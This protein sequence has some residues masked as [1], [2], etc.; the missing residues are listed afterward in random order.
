MPI[1]ERR[2]WRQVRLGEDS[3]LEFKE[4]PVK[5]GRVP[6]S[7]RNAIA[8]ELAAFANSPGGRLVFG[9]TDRREVKPLSPAELDA[10]D[11]FVTELCNDS[12][13]PPLDVSVHR[14]AALNEPG[15]GV[16]VV[17]VAQGKTVHQSPGGCFRR[18]GSS[19][20][21]MEPAEIRRLSQLRG[22]SDAE[23]TDTQVVAETA[24]GS[25]D[26]ELWR[27]YA[28][29]RAGDPPET[30]LSKLKFAKE[31]ANGV[32]RATVGGVLL[33]SR[34]PREWLP[35]AFIQA[36]CYR[37]D[38]PDGNQQL[39]AMDIAGPLDQQ[40]RDAVRFVARNRRVAARKEPARRDVPQYSERAVFEA[41]VN[42]VVHRDYAVAG[43]KI[44]LFMFGDRLELHSPGGLGNSM[45]VEDMRISQFT[46][47]ELL[48]SRLGQCP[49]G[50]VAGAGG[51]QYFIER[52]GEG[53]GVIED[54][55]FALAGRKPVFEL[56]GEREL[57]LVLPAA[58]RPVPEG[59]AARVAV[60]HADTG[61]PIRDVHILLVYPNKTYLEARTDAFGHADLELYANLPMTVLCAAPGFA[62]RVVPDYEPGDD[63]GGALEV[64]MRP[65]SD[66][67]SAIIPNRTG[68]MPGIRGRLNP[69]RDTLD[70]LYVYADNV[71]VND[72]AVQ[73][74]VFQLNEALALTDAFGNSATVWFREV[75]GA[76]SVFDYAPA[77][78]AEP[79]R[80]S[81][82]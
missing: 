1:D 70:R 61:K 45:T 2:F 38:R 79:L 48:A 33:G 32:L 42:A 28:S 64:R 63:A 20:R 22:Q 82:S 67:G 50:E 37:G 36:V 81:L 76:S 14:V 21:L 30:A 69:I 8:D 10:V 16:L 9:V 19:K 13:K 75:I 46:R 11:R 54:E 24:V 43:S 62:A 44:R 40:I 18:R 72:G 59:V 29:S 66:G 41:L 26:P 78:T 34:D 17:D 25:M 68:H 3:A 58:R 74:V 27:R 57:K 56:V 51:R 77:A 60:V 80:A 15:R 6:S 71:A 5:G 53:I 12:I 23:S 39:D 47:N 4:V 55:T 65:V 7:M 49:V 52:R 73:P 35:N 31:D